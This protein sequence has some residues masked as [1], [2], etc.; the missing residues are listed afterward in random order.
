M[1]ATVSIPVE[2]A[3]EIAQHLRCWAATG[4]M[5]DRVRASLLAEADALDT[6]IDDAHG[7]VPVEAEAATTSEV[8]A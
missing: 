5:H 7:F 6:A 3:E 8:A 2:M 4:R 1:S